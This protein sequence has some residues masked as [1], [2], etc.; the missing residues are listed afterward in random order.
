MW[1]LVLGVISA[2]VAVGTGLWFAPGVMLDPAVKEH[3]LR[4]HKWIMIASA[5]LAALLTVWALLKR[6]MPQGGKYAFLAGLL[7]LIVLIAKG[8]DYGGLMV[9]DYNAGGGAC[10][11]PIEYNPNGSPAG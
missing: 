5:S 2:A 10:G 11:Q 7:V 1:L 8:A 6:P 4:P 3:L 9:F